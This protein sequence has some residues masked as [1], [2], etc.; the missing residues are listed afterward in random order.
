MLT[1]AFTPFPVLKTERL[2]LRQL[3]VNDDKEIFAL[4]SDKQVN[5]YLD[6][7]LSNSIE[8]A[9]KLIIKLRKL[10]GKTKEFIGQ[11]L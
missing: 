6:R 8:D 4:R 3:S 7:D 5:K 2:T 1:N 10:S 9:R 11:L